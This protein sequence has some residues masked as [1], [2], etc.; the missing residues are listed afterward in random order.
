MAQ[1]NPAFAD[2]EQVE[3]ASDNA[4]INIKEALADGTLTSDEAIVLMEARMEAQMETKIAELRTELGMVMGARGLQEPTYLTS[5][6]KTAIAHLTEAPASYHQATV[7]CLATDAVEDAA[8]ARKAPL[9]YLGSLAQV[10]GQILTATALWV[11]TLSNSCSSSDQC[12]RGMYCP[13]GTI[14]TLGNGEEHTHSSAGKCA[15]CGALTPLQLETDGTCT[16]EPNLNGGEYTVPDAACTTRNLVSDP[17]YVGFNLAMVEQICARPYVART[18]LS[19]N[20]LNATFSAVGVASWC[21]TCVRNDGTVNP[22]SKASVYAANQA[23]MGL[24]DVI[25]VIFCSCVVAFS[26]VGELKDIYLC[27]LA[28]DRASQ[29]LGRGWR[30]ALSIVGGARRWLFL[31]TL[32][33]VV[34]TLVSE[35]G[36]DALTVCFNTVAIL[37]LTEIDNIAFRIGLSER[38]RTLVEDAGRVDLNDATAAALVRMKIAHLCLIPLAIAAPMVLGRQT[39]LLVNGGFWAGGVLESFAPGATATETFCRIVKVT[40]ACILGIL[41]MLILAIITS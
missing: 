38:M 35:L 21:E 30:L 40:G 19:G 5:A 17:N 1:L 37:F 22:A 34:P 27:Q 41:S 18:G 13:I 2:V 20:N 39:Y 15:Y 26:I 31:P 28:I 9:M 6:V 8:T 36:G 12:S 24:L 14:F 4:I 3:P 10:L 16:F 25:A 11:G 32:V 29:N 7:H 23:A 33:L